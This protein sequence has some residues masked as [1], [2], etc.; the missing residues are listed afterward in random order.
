MA[1]N[2]ALS[3]VENEIP[4]VSNLVK[5]KSDYDTKILKSEKK[6]TKHNY[7]KYI[8]TPEFNKLIA[9]NFAARLAQTHIITKTDFDNRLMSLNRKINSSKTKHALVENEFKKLQT[10]DLI[11]FRGK[12]HF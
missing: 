1:I 5:K 11:Y 4:N 2:S 3:T 6:V 10:F 7:D 12:S 8:T 9:E